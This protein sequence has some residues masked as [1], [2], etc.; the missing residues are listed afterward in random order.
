MLDCL[1]S[2]RHGIV[3]NT[4]R[5]CILTREKICVMHAQLYHCIYMTSNGDKLIQKKGGGGMHRVI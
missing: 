2:Q 4:K 1:P 5:S 3:F